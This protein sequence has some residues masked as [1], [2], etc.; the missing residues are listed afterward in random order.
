MDGAYRTYFP[1]GKIEVVSYYIKGKLNGTIESYY[2]NGKI[3]A[4]ATYSNGLLHGK[5]WLYNR[6][7]SPKSKRN[8]NHGI[9]ID[10]SISY[11]WCLD[12]DEECGNDPA[13]PSG[14]SIYD[15]DGCLIR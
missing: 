5:E 8:Y 13:K 2:P 10:S 14:I 6:D 4:L 7:G 1:N 12:Y 11:P 3:H 9:L 15:A